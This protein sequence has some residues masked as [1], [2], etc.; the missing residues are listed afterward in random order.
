MDTQIEKIALRLTP[1]T[2]RG[3]EMAAAEVNLTIEEYIVRFLEEMM[4]IQQKASEEKS[5]PLSPEEYTAILLKAREN[6]L[7]EAHRNT[8]H[9]SKEIREEQKKDLEQQ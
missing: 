5:G 9:V 3:L 8:L 7:H 2:Y 6:I 1:Q 4:D